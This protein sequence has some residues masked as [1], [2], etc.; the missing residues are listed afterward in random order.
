MLFNLNDQAVKLDNIT[1][2]NCGVRCQ[3]A[4]IDFRVRHVTS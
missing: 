1:Y 2:R 3:G 4:I